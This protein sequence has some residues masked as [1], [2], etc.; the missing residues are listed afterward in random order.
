MKHLPLEHTKLE[1]AQ[2]AHA[3]AANA[4][5]DTVKEL[6]P[7][8][9]II[10]FQPWHG[11]RIRAEVIGHSCSWTHRPSAVTVRNIKTGKSRD[12]EATCTAHEIITIELPAA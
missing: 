6:Y 7:R 11:K 3:A 10:E 9:S 1:D 5:R 4:L 2:K 8:G 12:I